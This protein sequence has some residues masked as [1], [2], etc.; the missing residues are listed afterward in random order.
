MAPPPTKPNMRSRALGGLVVVIV[1]YTLLSSP[2]IPGRTRRAGVDT[3]EETITSADGEPDRSTIITA[4][5]GDEPSSG[6]TRS[7]AAPNKLRQT[8]TTTRDGVDGTDSTGPGNA[9]T[10]TAESQR[11]AKLEREVKTLQAKLKDAQAAERKGP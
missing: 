3:P 7:H 10:S 5:T 1:A 2:P 9:A 4:D 6:Q 8:A 11:I